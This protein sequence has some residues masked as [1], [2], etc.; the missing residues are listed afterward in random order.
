MEEKARF[1]T[2][3][4]GEGPDVL[5]IENYT[6]LLISHLG[7]LIKTTILICEIRDKTT[8]LPVRQCLKSRVHVT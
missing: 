8:I 2:T 7:I 6:W 3:H 4:L 1:L 5:S